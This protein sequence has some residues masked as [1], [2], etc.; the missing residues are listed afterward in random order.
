MKIVL[1]IIS[2]ILIVSSAMAD[3]DYDGAE[4]SVVTIGDSTNVDVLIRELTED[5]QS[6][7]EIKDLLG[8]SSNQSSIN[9]SENEVTPS[10]GSI[11][12]DYTFCVKVDASSSCDVELQVREANSSIWVAKGSVSCNEPGT[13]CWDNIKLNELG[14]ANYRFAS[15]GSTSRIY[16]GPEVLPIK[17]GSTVDPSNGSLGNKY[18]YGATLTFLG[19][20]EPIRVELEAKNPDD[21]NWVSVGQ[22]CYSQKNINFVVDKLPFTDPF[23]GLLEYR[24]VSGDRVLGSFTGPNI[25][26][27]FRNESYEVTNGKYTYSVAVSSSVSDLPVYLMHSKNNVNWDNVDEVPFRNYTMG[28]GSWEVLEWEDYPAYRMFKFKATEIA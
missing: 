14:R 26:V 9:F 15:G 1:S 27:N 17:I 3:D 20:D 22:Q 13:L 6:R 19:T 23:L 4:S 2:L 21:Q 16:V 11:L 25:Y 12:T 7:E 18:V 28:N 24:F 5:P 10:N 8:S